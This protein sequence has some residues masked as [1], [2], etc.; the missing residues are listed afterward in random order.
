MTKEIKV[1]VRTQNELLKIIRQNPFGSTKGDDKIK[2]YVFFLYEEPKEKIEIP[3]TTASGEV[4]VLSKNNLNLFLLVK[5]VPGKASSPNDLIEKAF[6]VRATARNWDVVCKI[7]EIA[8][9]G[10]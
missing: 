8:G 9:K 3:F 5:K 2:T 4:N 10:N 6:K 1:F 7:I